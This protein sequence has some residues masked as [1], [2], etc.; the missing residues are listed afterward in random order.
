MNKKVTF[1]NM[2]E[3]GGKQQPR[4]KAS[5]RTPLQAA[6][7]RKTPSNVTGET[8]SSP[9]VL[10]P[11]TL[12]S[13]AAFSVKLAF[14]TA[15]AQAL[16]VFFCFVGYQMLQMFSEVAQP[17][18]WALFCSVLL[19]GPKDR[20]LE[21]AMENLGKI[22]GFFARLKFVLTKFAIV[23]FPLLFV[24]I[25]HHFVVGD[26]PWIWILLLVGIMVFTLLVC[27]AWISQDS[28]DSFLTTSLLFLVMF[29]TIVFVLFFLFKAV[30]ETSE[31]VMDLKE[32]VETKINDPKVG[33]FLKSL[34]VT[35]ENI[36][37]KAGFI[38]LHVEEWV[39][40]QGY[41]VTQIKEFVEKYED[42]EVL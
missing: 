26:F 5:G 34:N 20:V 22:G 6:I 18:F 35:A 14:Q 16:T 32:L 17:L 23:F 8:T 27:L 36:E 4:R 2:S 13:S 9:A 24:A 40:E 3:T 25:V 1:C 15:T 33:E 31:L 39:S 37:E 41:N 10:S 11:H 21:Y 12:D 42:I 19:K 28:Y 29:G 38:R 30:M 7:H